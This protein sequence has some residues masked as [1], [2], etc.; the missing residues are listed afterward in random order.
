MKISRNSP[1]FASIVEGEVCERVGWG[2]RFLGAEHAEEASGHAAGSAE[3]A[4]RNAC[5][6]GL[7][8]A[9]VAQKAA[10]A[11]WEGDI[12]VVQ[13]GFGG[14][15]IGVAHVRKGNL[16]RH[17][18]LVGVV[19]GARALRGALPPVAAS[20]TAPRRVL[21]WE[22]V[23]RSACPRFL[24]AGPMASP[25]ALRG[26][27]P[28]R[29]TAPVYGPPRS[30]AMPKLSNGGCLHLTCLLPFFDAVCC[31]FSINFHAKVRS[32]KTEISFLLRNS[33]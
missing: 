26:T 14:A 8:A 32:K 30:R 7:A 6:R 12:Y 24:L 3:R 33:A 17:V 20:D 1:R 2:V 27:C 31:R 10:P 29:P 9:V 25:H 28:T 18:F 13:D 15:R 23:S 22:D 19:L 21:K 16:H 4:N 11:L 5:E